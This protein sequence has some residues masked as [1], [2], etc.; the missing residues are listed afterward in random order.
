MISIINTFPRLRDLDTWFPIGNSV[1][2]S[3]GT[4]RRWNLAG[5]SISLKV[6][7]QFTLCCISEVKEG[8]YQLPI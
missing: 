1:A 7:F 6:G 5:E 2:N 3:Y 8:V 4:F